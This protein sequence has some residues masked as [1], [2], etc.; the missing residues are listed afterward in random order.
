MT[1]NLL[2][3]KKIAIIGGGPVGLAFAKLLQQENIDVKVYERDINEFARIE[4]GTL[5]LLPD[6]GQKAFEKAGV[7]AEY[8]KHS[9]PT[10]MRFAD[11][12]GNVVLDNAPDTNNPEI[13]RNDIR[14]IFFQSLQPNTVA[15][16]RKLVS[17]E[18]Q[19]QKFSLHFE[20][21]I[22]E[23][24]D[25]VVGANGIMSGVRKYITDT[26]AKYTG[27]VAIT[28]EISDYET[29]CPNFKKLCGE[30]MLLVIE[31]HKFFV[32]QIKANG[33][34]FYYI[35]FSKP[36]SWIKESG[37]NFKDNR[38]IS[39]FLN[40]LLVNWNDAYKEL[41]TAT[42]KFAL[43][44]MR[45]AALQNWRPHKNITLIGD[46]AHGM[47]PY[48][49]VGVNIGLLDALHL[50]ENLTNGKFSD[51]ESAIQDYENKMFEY[52]LEAQQ[53]TTNNG[54]EIFDKG[55]NVFFNMS[56]GD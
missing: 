52:S 49:G 54:T 8:Y 41:F 2:N 11:I 1:K 40:D 45:Q 53:E 33:E 28:G 7:L 5:D 6:M 43:M 34:L 4:G 21:G 55:I 24:A 51:I 15:W 3:D 50:A 47:P 20:N 26:Q 27:Q 12:N 25:L 10:G 9:R 23:T 38:Q 30:T 16:D 13:D 44:P 35:L 37:L 19:N 22:I 31:E 42:D 48:A 18:E 39:K 17:V 29:R 14:M 36:E 46:A 32:S 56:D